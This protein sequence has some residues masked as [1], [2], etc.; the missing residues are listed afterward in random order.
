MHSDSCLPIPTQGLEFESDRRSPEGFP[1]HNSNA[2]GDRSKATEEKA[3][4]APLESKTERQTQEY[5]DGGKE[6]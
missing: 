5:N 1:Y 2:I 3:G 6:P 4:S